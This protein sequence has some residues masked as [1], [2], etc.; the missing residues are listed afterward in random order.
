MPLTNPPPRMT[1][2]FHLYGMLATAPPP[3]PG[4]AADAAPAAAARA[5]AAVVVAAVASGSRQEHTVQPAWA[6]VG[7]ITASAIA[8]E[9]RIEAVLEAVLTIFVGP[10]VGWRSLSRVAV[11]DPSAAG[12]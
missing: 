2:F 1:T 6:T 8:H 4:A 12:A 5:P 3:P 11:D 10:F 9:G 7:K